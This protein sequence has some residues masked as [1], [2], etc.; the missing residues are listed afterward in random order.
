MKTTVGCQLNVIK[1]KRRN[2]LRRF[3][4]FKN[5]WSL[6]DFKRFLLRGIRDL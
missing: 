1:R 6:A 4:G 2:D 3:I 5:R